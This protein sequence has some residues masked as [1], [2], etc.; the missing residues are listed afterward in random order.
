MKRSITLILACFFLL[1]ASSAFSGPPF[2]HDP[3]I[4]NKATLGLLGT[5]NSLAYRVHEIERHLHSAGSWFEKAGTPSATHFADRIGTTGGAG[6]F[7]LDAGD[8]SATATWGDWVQIFGSGD[9]PARS[10]QTSFDPHELVIVYTEKA[11]VYYIQLGR[12]ASGA[13]ALTAGTYTELVFESDAVGAKAFGITNVQTGRAPAGSLLWART[14]CV[15]ENT[16]EIRF[17]IGIHE[18]EG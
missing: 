12:G 8:S 4:D 11:G 3:K 18:Y 14:L 5:S 6:P 10:G 9:T 15:G 2:S 13:A 17:F 16:S 1:V 7:V